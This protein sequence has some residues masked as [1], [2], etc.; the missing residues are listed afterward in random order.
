MIQDVVNTGTIVLTDV[1]GKGIDISNK[2]GGTI[3]FKGTC[4]VDMNFRKVE[5]EST[6]TFSA[7]TT[8]KMGVPEAEMGNISP[9]FWRDKGKIRTTS[10][11]S[12]GWRCGW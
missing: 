12:L 9:P 2:A 1:V 5:A 11:R 3:D 7:D 8:G 4:N 6:V 10:R